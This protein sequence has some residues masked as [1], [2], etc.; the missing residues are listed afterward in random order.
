MLLAAGLTAGDVRAEIEAGRWARLGV[1]TIG[2]TV[3]DPQGR[4]R[5]WWAVWESGSGSVLDGVTALEVAGLTGWREEVIHVSVPRGNRAHRL[6]GVQL[7]RSRDIGATMPA[8]VPRTRPEKAA[9]R[10]ALWARSDRQAAT[11]V[12][13]AVQQR[14]VPPQRLLVEWSTVGRTSRR[15]LLDMVVQDVCNGAH[16]LG[17]L[18][19]ASLCRARGLPEPTRQAVQQGRGG[20]IYLDVWWEELGVHVEIDG[21]QHDLGLAP[22]R[23]ALRHNDVLLRGGT[24]LRIPVLGLRLY[25]D[26]FLDQVATALRLAAARAS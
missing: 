11:L 5:W 19:F 2:I 22:V 16:S 14:L 20:R 25:P 6:P 17:E 13:M 1:H 9:V 21:F 24:S 26:S 18:D 8:G 4:A 10:A 7:H 12:A 15:A 23:D 3:R